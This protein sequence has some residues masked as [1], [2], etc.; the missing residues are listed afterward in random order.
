MSF[1]LTNGFNSASDQ[2]K[3]D[4]DNDVNILMGGD[5][6]S[7]RMSIQAVIALNR[8]SHEERLKEFIDLIFQ[9]AYQ[10]II[11][12]I[13]EAQKLISEAIE[14][15]NEIIIRVDSQIEEINQKLQNTTQQHRELNDAIEAKYFDKNEDGA[16]KNK[17]ITDTILA[18]KRRVGQKLPDDI[19]SEML[20]FILRA[21]QDFEQSEIVPVLE[22][23]LVQ[24]DD[25]R[26]KVQSQKET[27]EEESERIE[28]A[29]KTI[30]ANESLTDEER[31]I[32][33]AEILEQAS[34]AALDA[35]MAA[36]D[37]GM[38]YEQLITELQGKSILAKD[39][40]YIEQSNNETIELNQSALGELQ[41]IKPL[42]SPMP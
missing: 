24:F 22:N 36:Q 33:K 15:M 1:D 27:L 35:Q 38:E 11:E 39:L 9:L 26:N 32:R 12:D 25:F 28:N 20:I 10:Q 37:A 8:D 21:Q 17:A 30:D 3:L 40:T 18:Y 29:L 2:K 23:S 34:M 4:Y 7:S 19:S 6:I 16:Y 41:E 13:R 14:K 31:R 42:L 5:G